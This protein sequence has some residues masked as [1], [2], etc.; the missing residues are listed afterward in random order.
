MHLLQMEPQL[1]AVPHCRVSLR[2]VVPSFFD[3]LTSRLLL[4]L[5]RDLLLSF[6]LQWPTGT[7]L[8]MHHRN[9]VTAGDKVSS[10]PERRA[11]GY[12]G[13]HPAA[14][15]HMSS[16]TGSEVAAP[17]LWRPGRAIPDTDPCESQVG[18]RQTWRVPP[19]DQ[20]PALRRGLAP[21]QCNHAAARDGLRPASAARAGQWLPRSVRG[22]AF[23]PKDR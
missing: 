21:P 20:A 13:E 2:R 5:A 12:P 6:C 14:K 18:Y 7:S 3:L 9:S 22:E 23:A 11:V 4:L 19:A 15:S 17:V 8:R 16:Q 10:E 1:A